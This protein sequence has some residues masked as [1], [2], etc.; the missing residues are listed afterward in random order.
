MG[1]NFQIGPHVIGLIVRGKQNDGHS[2]GKME[3]HADCILPG[4][5]HVGFFGGNGDAS[6]GAS[7]SSFASSLKSWADGPSISWNRTGINMIGMVAYHKDLQRIRPMYVDARLAQKYKVKSTVLLLETTHTQAAL[8]VQYWKD[9]QL[10]PGKFNIVGC[11]CSTHA[12]NAF[13][14]AKVVTGGIPGLDTPNRLYKQLKAKHSGRMRIYSG[15]IGAS[16]QG[17]DN[18][19]LVVD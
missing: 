17:G 3:Q 8:F 2:P 11:N 9:L 13:I 4:G 12:S 14:A 7:G 5:E 19:A 18:Y 1:A 16:H 6:S 15:Y 10:N